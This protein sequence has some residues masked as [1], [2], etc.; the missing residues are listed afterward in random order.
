MKFD[1]VQ[2]EST[3]I[4]VIDGDRGKNYPHQNELLSTGFCLFLSAKNVTKS[5]FSF[6]ETQFISQ[7]KHRC[8]RGTNEIK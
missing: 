8:T 4:D 5:G 6:S 2:L 3:G 1:V 7:R